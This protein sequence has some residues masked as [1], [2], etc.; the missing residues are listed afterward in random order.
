MHR[1]G[2]GRANRA[3]APRLAA[4]L[5][6]NPVLMSPSDSTD[7]RVPEGRAIRL[8]HLERSS[9]AHPAPLSPEPAIGRVEARALR[10]DRPVS[11][12]VASERRPHGPESPRVDIH[13]ADSSQDEV[14][15]APAPRQNGGVSFNRE[16]EVVR[17]VHDDRTGDEWRVFERDAGS[18]PGSR[19]PRCL[20]FDGEGIVRR[21]WQYPSDWQSL[22][23]AALLSLMERPPLQDV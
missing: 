14:G 4:E 7:H 16:R 19:G 5:E 17:R 3:G 13:R 2:F 15:T 1:A 21:V 18:V 12:P 8:P 23:A 11:R 6:G 20:Y 9:P 10:A 22:P